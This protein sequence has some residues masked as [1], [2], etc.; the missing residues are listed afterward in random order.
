M[1]TRI[2]HTKLPSRRAIRRSII[3]GVSI[4]VLMSLSACSSPTGHALW[5][6]AHDVHTAFNDAITDLQLEFYDGEWEASRYGDV[7]VRCQE[8]GDEY[9]FRIT[10]STPVE[11]FLDTPT[12]ETVAAV[13]T[14]LKENGWENVTV[15]TFS[16]PVTVVQVSARNPGSHVADLLVTV[17]NAHLMINADS[18]CQAGNLRDLRKLMFG[19]EI[20]ATNPITAP[21]FH[22]PT[23]PSRFGTEPEPP[24]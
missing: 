2:N 21:K 19:D 22:D 13:E 7:P 11:G 14:F 8:S 1:N 12:Q 15:G 16:P 4:G 24:K 9:E 6:E 10:R 23:Q 20:S 18:T 17:Q 3:A 5:A